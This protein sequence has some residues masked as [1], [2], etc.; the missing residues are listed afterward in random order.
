MKLKNKILL[1]LIAL[2]SCLLLNATNCFAATNYTFIDGEK[3]VKLNLNDTFDSFNYIV[4]L[5]KS[6]GS[7]LLNY[8]DSEIFINEEYVGGLYNNNCY[9]V[10][11]ETGVCR[12]S[13]SEFINI[14][15]ID[16][17][18]RGRYASETWTSN[19][20]SFVDSNNNIYTDSTKEKLFY[21][22]S[23]LDSENNTFL[24][25]SIK[26]EDLDVAFN[27]ILLILPVCILVIIGFI[28]I[29]KGI[30]FLKNLLHK[31]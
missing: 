12:I 11:S 21:E 28:A 19:S 20:F 18:S 16:A 10:T 25:K 8:S 9:I 26:T 7:Y 22:N 27:E 4:L 24:D 30:S 6:D 5:K 14:E 17:T 13:S 2:I 3:T 23:T 1:I 31:A 29:R 15:N